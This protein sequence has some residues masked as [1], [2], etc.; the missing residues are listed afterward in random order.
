MDAETSSD[1]RVGEAEANA[2]AAEVVIKRHL[3][4]FNHILLRPPTNTSLKAAHHSCCLTGVS[5]LCFSSHNCLPPAG[6]LEHP[7]GRYTSDSSTHTHTIR[8]VNVKCHVMH[9]EM[10][11]NCATFH[12]AVSCLYVACVLKYFVKL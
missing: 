11:Y 6:S 4:Q 10:V 12:F 8:A 9:V 1:G 5:Q 7:M 3:H 2:V